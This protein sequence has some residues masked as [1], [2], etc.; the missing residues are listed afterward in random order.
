MY[1]RKTKEG[2]SMYEEK[3]IKYK[4]RKKESIL[5][6]NETCFPYVE[7]HRHSKTKMLKAIE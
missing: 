4:K 3:E 5:K 6:Q 1:N 7:K 2:I